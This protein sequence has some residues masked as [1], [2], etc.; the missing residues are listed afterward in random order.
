M[1]LWPLRLPPDNCS[2]PAGYRWDHTL[3]F[4]LFALFLSWQETISQVNNNVF[5]HESCRP[6]YKVALEPPRCPDLPSSP[7]SPSLSYSGYVYVFLV[8]TKTAGSLCGNSK[9]LNL[10]CRGFSSVDPQVH[11]KCSR[12]KCL[13]YLFKNGET[14]KKNVTHPIATCH[15]SSS[16]LNVVN[17][18][19]RCQ[20]T[21]GW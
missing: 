1:F 19:I 20:P 17:N 4:L 3:S 13:S 14:A 16:F 18:K 6:R 5:L 10:P 2:L 11:I 15:S 9:F 7:F 12:E 21:V 8:S